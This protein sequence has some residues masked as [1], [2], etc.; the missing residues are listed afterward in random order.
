MKAL[1]LFI[2]AL[3][4]FTLFSQNAKKVQFVGGA[5]SILSNASFQTQG[6]E[7]TITSRKSN[8]GYALIDLGFKINP[9][10]STEILGMVRIKND[11]GG[12]W[13][14][15]VAF[16]VRQIYVR[17]VAGRIFRYQIGNID[18]KL[19]PYTFYNH[20]AD[21]ILNG[22]G[23]LKMKED[24]LNYES[25][26]SKN[27]TWRQQGAAIDFGLSFPKVVRDIK[28]NGFITRL[29]PSN[30]SNIFERFFGGGNMIVNQSK[31][32]TFGINHA[33]VF[34]L[35]GTATALNPYKNG[36][37]S[38]TYD[39]K[40]DQGN[41]RIGLKGENGMSNAG[42]A[43]DTTRLE[44]FFANTQLYVKLKKLNLDVAA[45]Y[46]NNG[47]DFR[48]VGAQSKRINYNQTNNFFDRYT[49][50]QIQ[51]GLS[52]Y[53]LYNDPLLYSSSIST[54]IMS[55]DP[56]VNNALPYGTASF[57]RKGIYSTLHYADSLN[58]VSANL[59]YYN[60]SE[61]RGQGTLSLKKF[62]YIKTDVK[63]DLGKIFNM[64]RDL[65]V[66]IGGSYQLTKRTSEIAFE[67]VSLTSGALS[68]SAEFELVDKL[69]L[70]ANVYHFESKGN[71]LIPVR[72]T[73]DEIINFSNFSADRFENY[74]AGGL[75]FQFN[76]DIY[77]SAFYETNW[78]NGNG[79]NPYKLNQFMIIYNMKF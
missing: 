71:D 63:V 31:Y 43:D 17:G 23:V 61:V 7:D 27:N 52:V 4:S 42:Y 64:K 12:F 15:N 53:D 13:G 67:Q 22:T 3:C 39:V 55:Y 68:I 24:I 8:G 35:K 57:N 49:N 6:E 65:A 74:Y 5:R 20:N 40:F 47:A 14:S 62:N 10:A 16:D 51:R 33:S 59:S 70:L 9:N 56:S 46:M 18:Y 73:K 41:W 1:I 29:N 78:N 30:L 34:D 66:E 58:K 38:V 50:G 2:I 21:M 32:L 72:N 26:Y 28:F 19:T 48:S 69:Y 76:E 25:F 45:G 44:D 36:V 37:S 77:L 79:L 75:K 60:L 54:G 11:L